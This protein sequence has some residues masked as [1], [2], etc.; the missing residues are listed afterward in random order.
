[1]P[2]ILL[3]P[4]DFIKSFFSEILE[5]LGEL[6]SGKFRFISMKADGGCNVEIPSSA[7]SVVASNVSV[8]FSKSLRKLKSRQGIPPSKLHRPLP[9]PDRDPV[10]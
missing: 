3:L 10:A 1:M 7:G 2:S 4:G 5:L 8:P 9:Q 6:L